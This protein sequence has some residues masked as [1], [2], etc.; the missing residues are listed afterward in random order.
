MVSN[1]LLALQLLYR[2]RVQ[3]EECF[4]DLKSLFGFK[5]LV[6]KEMDQERVEMLFSLVSISMGM[7]LMGYEKSGYR[8]MKEL[9]GRRK[10]YSLVRVIK[11]VVKDSWADFKLDPYFSLSEACC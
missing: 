8:W 7:L 4:R 1:E 11:R 2:L 10:V 6:L 9:Y 3:I 5:Y